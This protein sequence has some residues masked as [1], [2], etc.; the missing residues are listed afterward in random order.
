[1]LHPTKY[2]TQ[3]DGIIAP[4]NAL[5]EDLYACKQEEGAKMVAYVSKMFAIRKADLP[6]RRRKE[7]TA[8]EMRERGRIEREKRNAVA[9][10]AAGAEAGEVVAIN[11]TVLTALD[12]TTGPTE[13][14]AD[15]VDDEDGEALIGFARIYS[16][17]IKRG[18]TVYCVAPKYDS[19]LS[20]THQKNAKYI[21]TAKITNLYMM[22]GRELVPVEIVPA[23]NI[24]AIGGLEGRV[25]RNATLCAANT[26]G[27]QSESA[28]ETDDA[29]IV[30]LAGVAMS[31][32]PI[33]RVALE[34]AEPGQS[35]PLQ[36]ASGAWG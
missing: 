35:T 36:I 15:N 31:A 9:A 20:P 32:A 10:T 23:G 27:V 6:E 33:V 12:E 13:E 18:T 24:F 3:S 22:M 2:T 8:E 19:H 26:A 16:G 11:N 4:N 21:T 17:T 1:M 5:E 28:E 34:P 29:S 7:V 30:N 25:L 14:A